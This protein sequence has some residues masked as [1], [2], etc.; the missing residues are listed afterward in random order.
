[1]WN[2]IGAFFSFLGN[3]VGFASKRQDLK[4]APDVR[5]N[6]IA[7]F[8]NPYVSGFYIVAMILL[9][10]HLYHGIWSMF[11]SLGINHPRY[12]PA[13]QKLSAI[14][15]ILICLG[16]ISIPISVLLGLVSN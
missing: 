6:V 1:M 4:N 5:A 8:S 11:Q 9:C 10:L 12:T 13:L 15:S 7:G 16:N 2:T 3:L 14:A